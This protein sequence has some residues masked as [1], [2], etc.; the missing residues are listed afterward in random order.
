[1]IFMCADSYHVD[2]RGLNC[3]Q[4]VLAAKKALDSMA[5][6]VLTAIVDNLTAKENVV[7]FAA[8]QGFGGSV[9]QA[10]EIYRIRISKAEQCISSVPER[11]QDAVVYFIS[12]NT[13]GQGNEELGA[14]LIKSFFFTISEKTPLPKTIIFVNSGVFLT[15]A[16][17]PV[18]ELLQ[19][20]AAQGVQILSCGTCLDFY[21]IKDSL[22]VGSI[23]NMYTIV[24]EIGAAGKVITI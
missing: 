19:T 14:I 8:S 12:R 9:E 5:G 18:L 1:V 7:K 16:G 22:A 11:A 3:P 4:P 20:L 15:V 24:D 21:K 6:G 13:L 17:S 10:G 23:S 2:A